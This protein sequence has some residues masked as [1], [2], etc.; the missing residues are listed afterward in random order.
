MGTINMAQNLRWLP[1]LLLLVC[2]C[3]LG[4]SDSEVGLAATPQAPDV[5]ALD[6]RPD[7]FL[8]DSLILPTDV[9]PVDDTETN[10]NSLETKV[11]PTYLVPPTV[12]RKAHLDVTDGLAAWVEIANA[13]SSPQIVLWNFAQNKAPKVLDI[14]YVLNPSRV[15]IGDAWIFYVDSIWGDDDIFG[16]RLSD[17]KWQLVAGGP[18]AQ[19]LHDVRNG[20]I[21][22]TDCSQCVPGSVNATSSEIYELNAA[23]AGLPL[24]L[25]NNDVQDTSPI[26]GTTVGGEAVIAWVSNYSNLVVRIGENQTT[27][28]T[29]AVLV[30]DLAL[31]E[32]R[33]AWRASPAIINPDS[34]I[35]SPMIINPDSMI[36]SDVNLTDIVTGTT[37]ALTQHVELGASTPTTLKGRSPYIAF[38]EGIMNSDRERVRVFNVAAGGIEA[39]LIEEPGVQ[40]LTLGKGM[41]GFIAP[42]ADN[43]GLDDVWLLAF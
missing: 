3:E 43:E 11:D 14:P 24:R 5:P 27:Y 29:E 25:S 9:G 39:A 16:I 23:D 8:E 10:G 37:S 1:C 34:M 6:I 28:K 19:V 33:I 18:G 13:G 35:P 41:L 42:R 38:A 22:Y 4:A 26:F 7:G 31:I 17:G 30:E 32:G 36:P 40:A 15:R 2:G 12:S 20:R 21:L